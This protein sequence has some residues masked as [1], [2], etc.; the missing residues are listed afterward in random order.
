MLLQA[1]LLAVASVVLAI[2]AFRPETVDRPGAAILA[3]IGVAS[4]AAVT[5]L[6]RGVR[7]RRPWARSPILVLELICL[8]IAVTVVQNDK[9]IPGIALGISAVAV[10][11]LL[12]RSGQ[13]TRR[14]D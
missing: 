8:P 6:A 2:E 14:E 11:L 9:V 12:A 7:A 3:L 4:A 10:L 1:V 5:A 13:L